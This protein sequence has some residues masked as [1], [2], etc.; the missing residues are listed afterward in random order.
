MSQTCFCCVEECKLWPLDHRARPFFRSP[1]RFHDHPTVFRNQILC[2]ALSVK[3]ATFFAN[4]FAKFTKFLQKFLQKVKIFANF[5]CKKL[6]CLILCESGHFFYCKKIF[7]QK[8]LCLALSVKNA[9]FFCK[10]V[11]KNFCKKSRIFDG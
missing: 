1:S 9:T 3:N 7:L 4:F 8:K 11:C 6:Q 2:L 10:K 5:F